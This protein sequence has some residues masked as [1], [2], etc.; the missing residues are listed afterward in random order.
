MLSLK[1]ESIGWASP[2]FF[3]PRTLARTWGTHRVL[4]GPLVPTLAQALK[5]LRDAV[6]LFSGERLLGFP[7]G[8]QNGRVAYG[9]VED[10]S[11]YR[12]HKGGDDK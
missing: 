10:R 2:T 8:D 6:D 12:S 9:G 5:G 3:G 7:G 1:D 11:D 4:S